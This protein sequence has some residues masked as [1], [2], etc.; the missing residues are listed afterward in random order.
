MER[1]LLLLSSIASVLYC[2]EC[3][4]TATANL[5]FLQLVLAELHVSCQLP[6]DH[7]QWSQSAAE[8]GSHFRGKCLQGM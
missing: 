7:P 1:V 4:P 5:R 2:N 3:P 6:H 8:G